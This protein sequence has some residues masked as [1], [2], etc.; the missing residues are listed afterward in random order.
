[1]L[2]GTHSE[3]KCQ[4]GQE[5][6]GIPEWK[7]AVLLWRMDALRGETGRL[8]R[9]AMPSVGDKTLGKYFHSMCEQSW[10]EDEKTWK[11][12]VSKNLHSTMTAP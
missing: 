8:R 9:K 10:E 7:G 11:G 3:P 5:K 1:M 2:E 4:Q 6:V 12:A